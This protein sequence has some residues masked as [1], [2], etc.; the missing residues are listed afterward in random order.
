MTDYKCVLK[1]GKP[2]NDNETISSAR[3]QSLK[4]KSKNWTGLDKFGDV[5]SETDWNNGPSGYY[6]H[7]SCYVTVS[8]A[9]NL[10]KAIKRKEKCSSSQ[11]PAQEQSD[12]DDHPGDLSPKRLRSSMGGPLHDKTKCVWCMKGDD[13]K[14]PNRAKS[15]LSRISTTS[16]WRSFKRHPVLIQEDKQ[17]STRLSR[18]VESTSALADPFANDIMY[19]RSCWQKYISNREFRSDDAMHLQNVSLSDARSLFFRHVDT[20]IFEEH[21]IRSMQSL[22]ADYKRIVSDYGYPVGDVKSSYLKELLIKEYQDKI[23]FKERNERNKSDW[24]FDVCGG[25]DY[26]ESVMCSLNIS[27][28]QLIQNTAR[29]LSKKVKATSTVDWPPRVDNLEESEEVCE[30]LVLLLTWLRHPDRKT[31][32]ISPTTLSLASMITSYVTRQR[33]I[34]TINMGVTVHGMTRSK[35]LVE[36]LHR[37]GVCISYADTLL[38]YDH[39]AL[40][41]VKASETCPQEIA[42]RKPAIVIVDNDDFKIDTITGSAA[43]A[44]RTNVM[45]VQPQEYEKK[46]DDNPPSKLAKKEISSQLKEKCAD[47]TQVQQ[48]RC[49]PGSKSEP[50]AREKVDAPVDGLSPQRVRSVIHALSRASNDGTRPL[51]DKQSVPAYSGAQSCHHPPPNRSKPYYHSTYDEPPSKSVMYSIMMRLLAA[52]REKS[53]PFAFLVGDMPTYKTTVQIKA[54]N[55]DLFKNIIPILG[56][57][58]QQMSYIYAVYKRFAGS[59]IADILVAAEIV[60][61]GSVDQA[62]RGKHYRRG[63][64]C[65]KLM[66]ETL[67]H[68]RLEQILKHEQLSEETRSNL[69]ILRKSL[70]ESQE[71]LQMA[72]NDL[73]DSEE[74]KGLTK[75]VYEEVGTDMGDFWLSFLEMTDPLVQCIDACHC[76]NSQEYLSS[77][78]HMLSGLMVYDNHDYGRWL[79]DYWAKLSTLP[80]EQ[81]EFFS[82]HFAQSMTGL[83]YSCQP[84]DLWI[85]TTMN[86]NSKLKSGWLQLL[87]NEKQLFSTTRNANNVARVKATVDEN[88]KCKRRTRKHVECQPARMKKDEQAIQDIRACFIEFEADPFDESKPALRSLQSGL[89]ASPQ[90]INDLTT[91]MSDGQVQVETFLEERVFAKTKPL[92]ATIHR[93]KRLNFAKSRIST[94]AGAAVK[95]AQM[96]KAGLATLIDVAEGSGLIKLESVLEWRVTDECLSVF[97]VDGS[98]RKTCKS[99]LLQEFT[100]DSVSEKPQNHISLVDMGLIW[101]LATPSSD[102][103]EAKQ[104]D[105]SQYRWSDYLDKIF[106][107]VISRHSD[108]R[109]IVLVNDRYDL[110]FSIK[111]D[112]HE[113]RA[114]KHQHIPNVF[115]KPADTFP[116][117][118]E[119]NKLM[120]NSSN[121]VRLQKLLKEHIEAHIDKVKGTIIYCEG[122]TAIDFSTGEPNSDF[123]FKHPEADTM[124]LSVYARLRA[125]GNNEMVVLDSE[126][127][128]VYV[129]AAY[130]SHQLHGDLLI[131]R[132]D[133]LVNCSAM[134]SEDTANIIIPLHVISG[135]DHTSGFYGHGKKKLLQKCGNDPESVELLGRVGVSLQ[136][137]DD[138]KADMRSFV[139]RHIYDEKPDVTCGQARASKWNT[140]RKKSTARLPPDEDSLNLHLERT[141][142]ISYCQLHFDLVEHPSPIGHGWEVI[143][144]KCKPVRHSRPALPQTLK[145]SDC[146]DNE[147]SDSSSDE[148]GSE[149][150]EST[151]SE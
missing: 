96:E 12:D 15:K 88:L 131:K 95:V 59:G 83:P 97:N 33:T 101:R 60:V 148:E 93:N 117:S 114:A 77:T 119:F 17:L 47:L 143:N 18:L 78:Y 39:W 108:A 24:V 150:G 10:R 80:A 106:N 113:R 85:E 63:V 35:D 127:T 112:E 46:T 19:H 57:F 99:K 141:N 43:G 70:T 87:H 9:S 16:A 5:H 11:I 147:S 102:D 116:G 51:P 135:S 125:N 90:L 67:I 65:I 37:S 48:Y 132:K 27:D 138:T 151:D 56:A 137:Q 64:R 82:T 38:L 44:H 62:L 73:E 31:P 86:L 52:M 14:H 91:A 7:D 26:I 28:E 36:T 49:P 32:N 115:P 58:H 45:F 30:S 142:F 92:T 23:G 104:R 109:L 76:R 123:G 66:R 124:L 111:D 75:K 100:L 55:S 61:E 120:V 74:V 133:V 107:M 53:I 126:D 29:R 54:E 71:I 105:G 128:D 144:G 110:Q 140:M 84:M 121:K 118:V 103:R 69:E 22:L 25:G 79:P 8:S 20:V 139:L 40:M 94:P 41:D 4:E 149:I 13:L 136:L 21:E 34:S 134:L 98:M 129:Q 50:P 1:C 122:E 68:K 3:W 146:T 130:V 6:T 81:M 89:V 145:Q 2:C 42:D 72:H